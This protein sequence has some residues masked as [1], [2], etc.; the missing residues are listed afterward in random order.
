MLLIIMYK[1]SNSNNLI[2]IKTIFHNFPYLQDINDIIK[3]YATIRHKSGSDTLVKTYDSSFDKTKDS[4]DSS[5]NSLNRSSEKVTKSFESSA[6]T[7]YEEKNPHTPRIISFNFDKSNTQFDVNKNA[8]SGVEIKSPLTN[9]HGKS[10]SFLNSTV[11]STDVNDSSYKK[12][13]SSIFNSSS[14]VINSTEHRGTSSLFKKDASP[15]RIK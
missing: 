6:K 14:T 13:S 1:K 5:Y 2:S 3:E 11:S 7:S 8:N 15:A 10:S 4:F 12:T 9:G